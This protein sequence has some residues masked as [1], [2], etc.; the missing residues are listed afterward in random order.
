MFL[1]FV[2]GG[3]CALLGYNV[4]LVIYRLYFHPLAKFPGPK[5]AAATK[6]YECW[7]DV[8]V[9]EGGQYA[10]KIQEM[11]QKY[12][13]T[14]SRNPLRSGIDLSQVL[15]CASTPTSFTYSIR[16]IS[17]PYTLRFQRVGING[18]QLQG[19]SAVP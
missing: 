9:G 16:N 3:L 5:I 15:S 6:W 11:H 2:S 7:H 8:L 19:W 12:G 10:W 13:K 1:L 14:T 18:L 4:L 17:T